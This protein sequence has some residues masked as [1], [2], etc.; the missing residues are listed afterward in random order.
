MAAQHPGIELRVLLP[1]VAD[2][3]ERKSRIGRQDVLDGVLLVVMASAQQM[4]PVVPEQEGT[5]RQLLQVEEF[6]EDGVKIPGALRHIEEWIHA[7][8]QRAVERPDAL[9]GLARMRIG[10]RHGKEHARLADDICL[11]DGV[12]DIADHAELRARGGHHDVRRRPDGRLVRQREVDR[13]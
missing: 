4:E 6:A 5:V 9:E 12:V 10:K 1:A 11:D 13:D 7:G 2:Q 3:H 8:V